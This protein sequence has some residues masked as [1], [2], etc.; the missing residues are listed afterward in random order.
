MTCRVARLSRGHSYLDLVFCCE[1]GSTELEGF[2]TS[3]I[4]G[5]FLCQM[6]LQSKVEC[7]VTKE[8][9]MHSSER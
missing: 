1:C 6:C 9:M 5:P 8:R 3:G 4:M 2:Y 7:R